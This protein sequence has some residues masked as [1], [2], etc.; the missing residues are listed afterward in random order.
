MTEWE[1]ALEHIV[2]CPGGLDVEALA[3]RLWPWTP[4]RVRPY[5]TAE[6]RRAELRL[7]AKDADQQVIHDKAAK[8]RA[9]NLCR[10]L[11]RR[12]LVLPAV[13]YHLD[14]RTAVL[15]RE[16]GLDW[17]RP[18]SIDP[19]RPT[20][21]VVDGEAPTGHARA[22]L[23]ALL[24]GPLTARELR[25]TTGGWTASGKPRG[26]WT[27]A[28]GRLVEDGTVVP[29]SHRWPSLRGRQVAAGGLREVGG[30]S[31]KERRRG[32]A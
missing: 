31:G 10:E 5:R 29:P 9:T 3:A 17:L 2:R 6:E 12:G 11:T 19:E 23:E 1:R 32:A 7:R 13:H 21:T 27:R 26:A 14:G 25:T 20:L 16:R 30:E 22:I 18:F 28:L 15:L 8:R 24:E 4:R